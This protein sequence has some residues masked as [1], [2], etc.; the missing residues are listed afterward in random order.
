M[1]S[2]VSSNRYSP[3]GETDE[4]RIEMQ[5]LPPTQEATK[6]QWQASTREAVEAALGATSSPLIRLETKP[7]PRR[8]M[9]WPI[10]AVKKPM[11][12]QGELHEDWQKTRVAM[13]PELCGRPSLVEVS[14]CMCSF[15]TSLTSV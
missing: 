8:G 15:S 11:D 3:L 14:Y 10:F 9:S 7:P 13:E 6:P 1:P 12:V 5:E 2:S 4:V